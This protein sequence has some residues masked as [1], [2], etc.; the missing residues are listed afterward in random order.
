MKNKCKPT[1]DGLFWRKIYHLYISKLDSLARISQVDYVDNDFL[2]PCGTRQKGFSLLR[3]LGSSHKEHRINLYTLKNRSVCRCKNK[4]DM[5]YVLFIFKFYIWHMVR[6]RNH[7]DGYSYLNL[8]LFFWKYPETF[9]FLVKLIGQWIPD[10]KG[11]GIAR[12]VW[13]KYFPFQNSTKNGNKVATIYKA[14]TLFYIS[15]F[16]NCPNFVTIFCSVLKIKMIKKKY[17]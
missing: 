16:L 10:G 6:S 14:G 4:Y 12:D 13:K 3:D 15:A 8:S 2:S 5:F 1:A 17:L 11:R 9:I 7:Q